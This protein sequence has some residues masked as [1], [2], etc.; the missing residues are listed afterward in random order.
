M[1]KFL[2]GSIALTVLVAG[3]ALAADM[4][5][6]AP[7]YKAPQAPAAFTWTGFYL[8]VHGGCGSANT[9]SPTNYAVDPAEGP[10]AAF[11]QADVF[12]SARGS[13]CFGGGQIGYNYQLSNNL[14]VGIEIDAA[15]SNIGSSFQ[16]LQPPD[17]TGDINNWE[18]KLTAFGT[19]RARVGYA[20]GQWL[21]YVTGGWAWGRNR[22]SSTCPESCDPPFANTGSLDPQTTSNTRT[23]TGWVVGAGLEYALNQNWS[24]KGEY[25]H[26]DL[27]SQ[28]YNVQVDYDFG[29]P[30]GVDFGRLRID[31][32]KLGL[33]YRFGSGP[34]I[35]KY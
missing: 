3:P 5:V 10:G 9:P 7:I 8:G 20:F 13:G 17:G 23:H 14:V 31:T 34:V 12:T 25:L 30:P 32:I 26:L 21:P 15:K 22:L 2:L 18:S 24:M 1:R 11:P 6:K 33:N 27:G 16:W 28:R 35:A 29:V 19:V 4:R